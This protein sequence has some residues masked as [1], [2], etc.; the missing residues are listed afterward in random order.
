MTLGDLNKAEL[1]RCEHPSYNSNRSKGS[2]RSGHTDIHASVIRH[3]EYLNTKPVRSL[4]GKAADTEAPI[5][6]GSEPFNTVAMK[7]II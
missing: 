1:C 4:V 3:L 7:I 6:F 2:A 5:S